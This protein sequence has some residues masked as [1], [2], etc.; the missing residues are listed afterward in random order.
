MHLDGKSRVALRLSERRIN[1]LPKAIVGR[2]MAGHFREDASVTVG[3]LCVMI[4]PIIVDTS[5][6]CLLNWKEGDGAILL[7]AW[8]R[9][10]KIKVFLQLSV[11]LILQMVSY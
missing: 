1:E 9:Y 4:G 3:P 10:V 11:H 6:R 5:L 2:H 7:G 8:P